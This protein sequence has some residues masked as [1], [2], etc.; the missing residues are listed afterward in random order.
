MPEAA[1]YG[2][3]GCVVHR[4]VGA[5][6][7]TERGGATGRRR[8]VSGHGGHRWSHPGVA[9]SPE[10]TGRTGDP[11]RPSPAAARRLPPPAGSRPAGPAAGTCRHSR[12]LGVARRPNDGFQHPQPHVFSQL[13][14]PVHCLGNWPSNPL[15][16]R[17]EETRRYASNQQGRATN[18]RRTSLD[19]LSVK[20]FVIEC[21]PPS[22]LVDIVLVGQ[23]VTTA[24]RDAV[25]SILGAEG[26]GLVQHRGEMCRSD[27]A[28]RTRKT[29]TPRG[30]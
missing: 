13:L 6:D 24:P 9:E 25:D 26:W 18:A 16:S 21:F 27:R 20:P 17:Q 14:T 4:A 3:A 10:R 30:A 29:R 11:H 1:P 7:A 22:C 19:A 5:R 23:L 12:R 2:N 15:A 28:A 8:S